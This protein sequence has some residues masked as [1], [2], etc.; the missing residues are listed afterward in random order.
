LDLKKQEILRRARMSN[1][2]QLTA[3]IGVGGKVVKGAKMVEKW[4]HSLAPTSSDPNQT[5]GGEK[6]Q[7]E[8]DQGA[9][10]EKGA[11]PALPTFKLDN[12]DRRNSLAIFS[13]EQW[14]MANTA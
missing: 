6:Q 14:T 2:F 7:C 12:Q 1:A 13:L 3:S 4:S 5:G 8:G 9:T 10:A 11:S